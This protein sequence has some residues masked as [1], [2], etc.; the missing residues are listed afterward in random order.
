MDC[1]R[2]RFG[3]TVGYKAA[4][5]ARLG[6]LDG[7]LGSQRYSFQLLPA[8]MRELRL[9]TLGFRTNLAIDPLTGK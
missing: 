9:W 1:L 7:D 8:Y 4:Q 6:L 5:R 3:E 2:I